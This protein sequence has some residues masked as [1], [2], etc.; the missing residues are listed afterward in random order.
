MNQ[1]LAAKVA[2]GIYQHYERLEALSASRKD[3]LSDFMFHMEHAELY[4]TQELAW[5]IL[6]THQKNIKEIIKNGTRNLTQRL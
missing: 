2:P 3:E 6:S 5:M 1:L 4:D